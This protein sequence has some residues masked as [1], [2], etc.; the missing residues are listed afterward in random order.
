MMFFWAFLVFALVTGV[1]LVIGLAFLRFLLQQVVINEDQDYSVPEYYF[2]EDPSD[3]DMVLPVADVAK[4][5]D[6]NGKPFFI[7]RGK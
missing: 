6:P 4:A 2:R 5:C 1:V 3:G 7:G